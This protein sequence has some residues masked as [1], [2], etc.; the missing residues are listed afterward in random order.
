MTQTDNP[1]SCSGAPARSERI[2]FLT[3]H[4]AEP[5]L[6]RILSQMEP[7]PFAATIRDLGIQVA[8]LMTTDLIRRRL[9]ATEIAADL[10]VVPGRCRGDLEALARDYGIAFRRGP[11][12]V[13]DLPE[14]FSLGVKTEPEFDSRE[15]CR[16]FA[17]ITNAP[18]L[19]VGDILAKAEAFVQDGAQVIDLGCL[20]ELPFPHLAEAV[21]ALKQA[22]FQVSVDSAQ[23]AELRLGAAAGC[24]Y[25]LSLNETRLELAFE[26]D[27]I[28]VLIPTSEADPESLYRAAA[29]CERAGKP[30]IADPILAPIGFGL[31]RSLEHYAQ[32]RRRLPDA[33]I[34]MGIGN[35]T[36][37]TDADSS[38][39]TAMLFGIIAEL[40]ITEV[41]TVQDSPHCRRAIA[42]AAAARQLCFAAV[43][44]GRLPQSRQSPL[45]TLR[46]RNPFVTTSAE[47]AT[48][49]AEVRD[50][51]F[52]IEVAEDGIHLYNRD[53]HWIQIRAEDFAP[54]LIERVDAAH[55]FYLGGELARAEIAFRLGKRFNQDEELDWGIATERRRENLLAHQASGKT[56]QTTK[57]RKDR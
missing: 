17:E 4:L 42:E 30:Y 11:D 14:F 50:S 29:A 36:E 12:D 1:D 31:A 35:L 56:R 48:T 15:S 9:A 3:G 8:G 33:R 40:G 45:L 19:T 23:V 47:I 6:R 27:A 34:L 51:N 49:V 2:L 25:L 28:P 26:T 38:G 52:R 46:D 21:Q 16:I 22:G 37:L 13:G 44:E 53:G 20:P 10:V 55:G 57:D 54:I 5:R 7:L 43:T 41:L 39:V 18:Q 24:D 32:C